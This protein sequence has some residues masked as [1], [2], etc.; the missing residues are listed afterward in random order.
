MGVKKR[1][2]D[3]VLEVSEG[4]RGFRNLNT[5]NKMKQNVFPVMII[6]PCFANFK[7]SETEKFF[8]D[9]TEYCNCYTDFFNRV[10]TLKETEIQVEEIAVET[11]N[12]WF[13]IISETFKKWFKNE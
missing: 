6:E 12:N 2:I 5:I 4:G 7:N 9:I 8:E 3:G 13:S 11:G 10:F 1:H